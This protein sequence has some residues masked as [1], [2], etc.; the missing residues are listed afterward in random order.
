M[1]R[2]LIL[3]AL[4]FLIAYLAGR[5]LA[6]LQDRFRELLNNPVSDRQKAASELVA[7]SVCG[8][9]VPQPQALEA[10]AAARPGI[11]VPRFYCSEDCRRRASSV[12]DAMR[13]KSA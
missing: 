4:A 3:M 2:F 5:G 6:R 12:P 8:V 1:A 9:H 13:A 7:C 10:P 11:T